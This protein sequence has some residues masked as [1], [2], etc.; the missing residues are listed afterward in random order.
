VGKGTVLCPPPS[1][2]DVEDLL[3][4]VGIE[5]LGPSGPHRV[6]NV[7]FLKFESGPYFE[8]RFSNFG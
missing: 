2:G 4:P 7:Q 6:V 1:D 5:E 3:D 8:F